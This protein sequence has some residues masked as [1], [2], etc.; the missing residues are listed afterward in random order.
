MEQLDE[1]K[2]ISNP[3]LS[4]H[5]TLPPSFETHLP[6]YPSNPNLS[7]QF[8]FAVAEKANGMPHFKKDKNGTSGHATKH[9]KVTD[10]FRDSTLKPWDLATKIGSRMGN[11]GAIA[12]V[13]WEYDGCGLTTPSSV[14][15]KHPQKMVNLIVTKPGFLPLGGI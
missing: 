6:R 8:R 4:Q 3:I 12:R 11:D 14:D 7:H 15:I 10:H 1:T 13:S 5:S 2:S 9:A